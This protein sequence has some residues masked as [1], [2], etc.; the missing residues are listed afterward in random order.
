M[1]IKYQLLLIFLFCY[2]FQTYGQLCEGNLGDPVVSID[3][4]SGT[5]R[6]SALGSSITAFT[7]SSAGELDEGEYTIYNTTSGLKGNAWHVTSDHTGDTNGHMMVIN[8]AVLAN[9]GVFYTKTV[10]GLCANTTFEFSA[11]LINLMNPSVGTDEY[12]PDVTFRISDT[13][14]N[15]LGSYNTGDIAQTSSGI[16]QQYGFFFTLEAETEV[17]ITILN[18]APSAHP[19]NDIALDDIAFK[20]CGPTITSAIEN[21]SS[22]SLEICEGENVSYTFQSI[23]SSGY[24]DPQYQW[25]YSDDSGTTWIDILGETTPDYI[26]TNTGQSGTFLYRLAVANGTNINSLSCRITSDDYTIEIIETPEALTGESNQTFCTTQNPTLSD[27]EVSDEAIWYDAATDGSVLS[28]TTNLVDGTTYY[29]AK[30][31]ISNC[32]SDVRFPVLAT[33]ISPSLVVN[34]I[35]TTICDTSNNNSEFVDLTIYETEISSCSDCIISYFIS[36]EEAENYSEEGHI[37]TPTNFEWTEDTTSIFARIDSLDKCYQIS[38]I[39]LSLGETPTIPINDIESICEY[40]NYAI[41]DAGYGFN[42]Y[43]WSTGETTQTVVVTNET[44]GDYWVTVTED[45]GT[46]SCDTTKEFQVILSNTAVISSIDIDDWTNN[47]N[48]I[49]VN[50]SDLD[51]GDYEYSL[52]DITYQNSNLFTGLTTGEYTV[53]VRDKNGCGTTEEVVYLLNYPKFF[54]PNDDGQH[55]TWFIKYSNEEPNLTIKIFDRY[56]KILKNLDARSTWD[57]TYNGKRMPTS[58]YWFVVTR[59]NGRNFTGHFTLKR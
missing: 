25:Q 12:H 11:W 30:L 50:L 46:Y 24:S 18:S 9:E 8:S 51:N 48:S 54:T 52:D 38:E 36:Q 7:Y 22:I 35:A 55:D 29:A 6:G 19:G 23:V 16:W 28:E 57:G 26:F 34:N 47:N 20:P 33:I 32:E 56:G 39:T 40:E 31:T 53:F 15:I 42:S 14:G 3:F 10:T 2:S 43:L 49:Q 21:E 13:S 37:D 4:G 5:G 45:Y 44:I 17:V 41:I 1:Y 27:I 58:D 59:D